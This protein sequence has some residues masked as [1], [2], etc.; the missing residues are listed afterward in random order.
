MLWCIYNRG[1]HYRFL[2]LGSYILVAKVKKCS[3]ASLLLLDAQKFQTFYA[4]WFSSLFLSHSFCHLVLYRVGGQSVVHSTDCDHGVRKST[5][6]GPSSLS[7][8]IFC[9][10]TQL[11]WPKQGGE[12]CKEWANHSS[13]R[14][15]VWKNLGCQSE[16]EGR[17]LVILYHI[18]GRTPDLKC[19]F[20]NHLTLG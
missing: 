15:V 20:G 4:F 17:G 3:F 8:T 5:F 7:L 6:S 11:Q 10:P 14:D 13:N 12:D 9:P 19:I 18:T 1:H 2:V 16:A